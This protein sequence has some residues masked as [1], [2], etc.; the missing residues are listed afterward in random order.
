MTVLKSI[1]FVVLLVFFS[2][3]VKPRRVSVGGNIR[4]GDSLKLSL[5][6]SVKTFFPLYND[7]IYSHRMLCN[8]Y[9][10]LFDLQDSS[11][12]LIPR[13]A[14][15]YQWSSENVITLYLRKGVKFFSDP[16]FGAE[17]NEMTAE[18]V[19]ITLE[20]ACSSSF[21]NQSSNGLIG[22]ITGSEDYFNGTTKS[23][24]GIKIINP[25]CLEITL[26]L[27]NFNFP[28]LLSSS[29]Y[30]VFS[31]KAYE[32]YK[33]DIL[34][35]PVGTGPF[36]LKSSAEKQITLCYNPYYWKK[37]VYGNQ[38][39]YLDAIKY[40]VYPNTKEEILAFQHQEIDF[41]FEVPTEKIN[42]I[43]TPLNNVK[44]DLPFAHKVHVVPG[45]R[46]SLIV[47]NQQKDCFQDSRVRKAIDLV[48][49]R[50]FI[51]NELLN[52]D[53][54]PASQGIA[55]PSF[56]YDNS[57]IP[58]KTMNIE[59]GKRL[60]SEAGYGINK[61][62]PS[63]DFYAVGKDIQQVQKYCN[64][65]AEKLKTYLNINVTLH[66]VN[67]EGRLKAIKI[68]VADIWKLGLNPDYPD[69]D[70]Y[71]GLFFSKNPINTDQNPLL[72]KIKSSIYDINYALAIQEK[73]FAKQ[74]NYFTGCDA[75]LNEE[76]WVLPILYEDYIIIQNMR[77]RGAVI[78][79]IG[80]IDLR[81]TYIKSL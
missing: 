45:S 62:F 67:Q 4:Y 74:N 27:P 26:N 72:P 3:S 58:K 6:A 29:K 19:K 24:S 76:N 39:P 56:Y 20:L 18:D 1:F 68:G 31:K 34:Y 51:A 47:L 17:S 65:I 25:Y 5:P 32:Y 55:P 49:D 36:S 44:E 75:I 10:P 28:K 35:H 41:L 57:I 30:A 33:N 13:L 7:D 73:N 50:D 54:I 48:L 64:Y 22:K 15:K 16:C 66:W 21:L 46:V 38:L 63:V 71:F 70:A 78:S 59:L 52:G 42:N 23:I 61:P 43:F 77:A 69:A 81:S 40:T 14:E 12:K 53:G 2:C 11:N 79:P 8:I 60:M 80:T 37:D 9:E